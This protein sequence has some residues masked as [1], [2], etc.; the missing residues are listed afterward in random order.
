M[1]DMKYMKLAID[2]A[3]ITKGQTSPNP[4]VAA[5]I[6]NDGRIVGIGA[7]LKTGEEHAEVQALNMAGNLA[8]NSTLYVTMEPCSHY[9]RTP[10]CV[11]RIIKE[12]IKR[13]VI[14]TLD[15]NPLV[16][17]NS[18]KI[19]Q[20]ANINVEVG[21]YENEAK[22]LNEDFNKY[23]T[24]SKPFVTVKT[25]MTLDGKIA[26][27][28]GDGKW[29]TSDESRKYVHQLRHENDAILVGVGTILEDNPLLTVRT[30]PEGLNPIRVII[31]TSLRISIDS[32]VLIDRKAPTWIFTTNSAPI[33][34]INKL[35]DMDI[36]VFV[37]SGEEKVS[38]QE[39]IKKLGEL[40]I[41]SV[42]VEGGSK[43]IGDLFDEELIDKYIA[44]IS[45]KLV[46]GQLSLTS[47]SGTGISD[48]S[49][50]VRLS[51]LTIERFS[52]DICIT[53][54]PIW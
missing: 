48:M 20:L 28:K 35:E 25:A 21:I 15:P 30:I 29:I 41:T 18:I 4:V 54:Y 46:G 32:K 34:K 8:E 51:N 40:G 12:K 52:E 2:L 27:H 6:I 11:D 39:V 43:I 37:T 44:F 19:L 26:T 36:R 5:I 49:D 22:Q 16:S 47:I 23:I 33:D 10:P 31:D 14:A 1:D 7:H 38:L 50:A 3:K 24:T 17:G 42:L 45:P 9:G 13:V 53:G